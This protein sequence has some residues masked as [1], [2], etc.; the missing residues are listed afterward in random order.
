VD[1]CPFLLP[2]SGGGVFPVASAPARGRA[3]G[4]QVSPHLHGQ[5]S[6]LAPAPVFA[7]GKD[8]DHLEVPEPL[9]QS[10]SGGLSFRDREL[11]ADRDGRPLLRPDGSPVD[12]Q[13]ARVRQLADDRVDGVH[14]SVN[15]PGRT[16]AVV[17]LA[18][19]RPLPCGLRS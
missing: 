11:L 10:D 15:P 2:K 6:A 1:Q 17:E 16:Q 3:A 12:Q 13:H 8:L 14:G 5:V 19:P 18:E 9:A 7:A 4:E